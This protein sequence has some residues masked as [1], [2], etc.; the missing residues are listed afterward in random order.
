MDSEIQVFLKIFHKMGPM[1]VN[2]S[3]FLHKQKHKINKNCVDL[4]W[5]IF[6]RVYLHVHGNW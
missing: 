4:S 1:G 5:E 2:Q 6:I 3:D